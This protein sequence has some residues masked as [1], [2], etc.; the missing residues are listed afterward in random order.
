MRRIC[1]R[2]W[3]AC[4]LVAATLAC[5]ESSTRG[6]PTPLAAE[7]AVLDFG[8]V[9]YG[10]RVTK[11][12]M[13]RNPTD[14]PL[15]IARIGPSGCQ[16]AR[17]EL[18]LPS[19]GGAPRDVTDGQ[20]L[21]LELPAGAAA[22]LRFTLDTSRYREPISRKVGGI[23]VYLHDHPYLMLEWGADVWT[24]FAVSPWAIEL[25]EVGMR[26]RAGGRVLVSAHDE[27][28][29]ELDA[30][31]EVDGWVVRSQR[32]SDPGEKALYE[33]RVTAPGELPEGGFQREFRFETSLIG[34]PPVRFFVNGVA[35][36]DLALSP[37][38]VMLDPSRGRREAR[39][40]LVNR[41]L[42]GVV[43]DFQV[44]GLEP[45]LECAEVDEAPAAQRGFTLR[46]TGP[47]PATTVQGRLRLT[48]GDA[49]RPVLELPY[50]VLPAR[51]SGS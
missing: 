12:W 28:D 36:P 21:D 30:N 15:R 46:W 9:T 20:P 37:A 19:P 1:L 47:A 22:E 25:G 24:P 51:P 49:E 5:G 42:G 48:T 43:G 29:F 50:S 27:E 3:W 35:R 34:A 32:L 18:I 13:L 33:I 23:G 8:S 44:D 17:L 2:P 11:S 6:A 45:G 4:A 10:D 26:Q 40:T 14:A 31:G 16:C 7:P 39:V 41:A 38:R